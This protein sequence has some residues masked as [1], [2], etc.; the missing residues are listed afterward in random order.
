VGLRGMRICGCG[1]RTV[2][3]NVAPAHFGVTAAAFLTFVAMLLC[4]DNQTGK[5]R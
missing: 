5:G 3:R 2:R 1:P 4:K